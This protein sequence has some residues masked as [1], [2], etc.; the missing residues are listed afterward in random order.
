MVK[1][2]TKEKK[3]EEGNREQPSGMRHATA[4]NNGGLVS[5]PWE[6]DI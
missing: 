3:V 2:I 1:N 6:G 5:P 4:L